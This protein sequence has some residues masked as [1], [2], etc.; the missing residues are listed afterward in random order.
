MLV[1][2]MRDKPSDLPI[3][4][5]QVGFR[6]GPIRILS[7][8]TL[9]FAPGSTTV[10]IG[11]NGSGKTTLLKLAMGLLEP[12]EGRITFA[13]RSCSANRRRAFVFQKPVMLRRSAAPMSPMR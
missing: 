10:L 2:P 13:G 5:E 1:R 9:A 3:R 12:T 8:V 6:A 11:P 4:F 7:D